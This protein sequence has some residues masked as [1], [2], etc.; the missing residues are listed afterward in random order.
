[1]F[2]NSNAPFGRIDQRFLNPKIENKARK[3]R[4]DLYVAGKGGPRRRQWQSL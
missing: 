2:L 1:M 3:N 4:L